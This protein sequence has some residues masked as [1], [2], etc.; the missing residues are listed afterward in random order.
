MTFVP[1]SPRAT[2]P[3]E[4]IKTARNFGSGD[5]LSWQEIRERLQ[6]P[7]RL[8]RTVEL[9]LIRHAQT[10]TNA[11]KRKT[12]SLD[13]RLSPKGENQAIHLGHNLDKYYNIA[14]AS[15]LQRTEKTL[16]LALE[17][18]GVRVEKAFK[19]KRLNER[20]L[21]VLEGEKSKRIPE[22]EAGDLNYA[23]EKGESYSEVARRIFSFLLDL[24]DF[25]LTDESSKVLICGHMGPMRIMV[26]ILQ[27]QE[28][29]VTV[30]GFS[31]PNAELSRLTWNQLTIPGFLL[32]I[33]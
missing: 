32:N 28:N 27:E 14:F 18:G 30:L 2:G 3:S 16:E 31:F 17:S 21:G 10:E 22:Y 9:H 1:D 33:S 13:V 25:V 6:N 5:V 12:G 11:D 29:P 23:P 8:P 19:D 4:E 24:A 26:G 7:L 15:Q 20:S